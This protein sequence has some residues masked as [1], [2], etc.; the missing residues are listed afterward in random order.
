MANVARLIVRFGV[1]ADTLLPNVI[2]HVQT[3]ASRHAIDEDDMA[4]LAV[5]TSDWWETDGADYGAVQSVYPA[6]IK[7]NEVSISRT[8]P[9]V[10]DEFVFPLGGA[11]GTFVNVP[12]LVRQ[13]LL[14]PQVSYMIGLRT[15]LDSRRGRGRI[16]LPAFMT[17]TGPGTGPP[18]DSIALGL[19]G[20][21]NERIAHIGS[22]I[23]EAY[24]NTPGFDPGTFVLCVYSAVDQIGRAVTHFAIPQH[25]RTQRR[26]ALHPSPHSNYGLDGVPA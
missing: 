12:S 9:T 1:V 14:P 16:Y 13:V 11:A 5:A 2:L 18:A 15:A 26:R 24:Y 25:A 7:L 23:A 3:V 20:D 8:Q 17:I 22:R 21:A 19:L 6:D 10:T 4:A